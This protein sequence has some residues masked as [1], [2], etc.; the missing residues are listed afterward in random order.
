[1]C[2]DLIV[3]L[4]DRAQTADDESLR[5]LFSVHPEVPGNLREGPVLREQL[6]DLEDPPRC[7]CRVDAGA[8]GAAS[9]ATSPRAL[10]QAELPPSA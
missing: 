8:A 10:E 2:E 3:H 4:R 9:A 7:A 5:D 1:M 6:A